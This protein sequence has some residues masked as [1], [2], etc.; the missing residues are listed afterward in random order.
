MEEKTSRIKAQINR[1]NFF[2]EEKMTKKI[3]V[4]LAV[5]LMAVS[6]QA[7]I[8]LLA[9]SGFET[10]DMTSWWTYIVDTENQ[11]ATI[12]SPG[13]SSNFSADLY[14]GNGSSLQLGQDVAVTPGAALKV[15]VSYMVPTGSWNGAGISVEF[16]D[17]GGA[18][19]DYAYTPI[20]NYGST[21]G[22]NDWMTFEATTGEG[23]WVVPAG[24]A[25]ASFKI[26]QWGW[27]SGDGAQYDNAVFELI[28]EPVTMVLLGLGGLLAARKR[29]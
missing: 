3:L 5:S 27:V 12:V 20:Y 24:A 28:P 1:N 15:A 29:A 7:G 18:Y 26:C 6:A 2:G 8:N 9:N 4:M 19:L 10:G 13:F 16:K 22:G 17:A 23:S 25:N 14:T 11:V 21:G